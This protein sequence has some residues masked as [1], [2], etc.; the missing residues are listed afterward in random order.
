[1]EEIPLLSMKT[2]SLAILWPWGDNLL[3][4]FTMWGRSS[5]SVGD[6]ERG[7]VLAVP[8]EDNAMTPM[9]LYVDV[10][11][12]LHIFLSVDMWN[13]IKM[14]NILK[15]W[16][17]SHTLHSIFYGNTHIQFSSVQI[18]SVQIVWVTI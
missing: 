1:V 9:L 14:I 4:E 11:D 3:Q 17:Q 5:L 8:K 7:M 6:R 18:G 12:N 2:H 13:C 10:W 16:S 15:C